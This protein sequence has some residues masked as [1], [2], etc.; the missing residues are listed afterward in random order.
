MRKSTS[1]I[2][3]TGSTGFVG[4][5]LVNK[6]SKKYG[7]ENIYCLVYKKETPMELEG[8]KLLDKLKVKY[9]LVDLTD[10]KT[11]KKYKFDLIIHLAAE[12]DTSKR[13]HKVN[14]IGTKN[15]Y[16]SLVR[17]DKQTYFIHIGT[18]VEVVGRPN[19]S[20]PITENSQDFPTNEYTRTK[21]EGEKFIIQKSIDDKFRL[22]VIRPNTIYGKGVR[23]NSLFDMVGNMI[24]NNSIVTKINW[25]GKSALIHVEDLTKLILRFVDTPP[26]PGKPEKYLA[27]SENLTI[28]EISKIMHKKMKV[29]FKHFI[30]PNVF[31]QLIKN[32]RGIIPIFEN[33][34]PYAM[35]NYLWRFGIIVDNVVWCKSDKV[36]KKFNQFKPR[37][38]KDVAGDVL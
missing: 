38:F 30:L 12:T 11:L 29:K 4:K 5:V 13:N 36:V 18:M 9:D 28:F 33:F 20:L 14:D 31:W 37:R 10:V 17:P 35:Y 8:R 16:A 27:Y 2:L 32:V 34:F 1:R 7:S 25:P 22:T 3:I 21:L 19:C 15:L 26:Q 6:L 23:K 24:K